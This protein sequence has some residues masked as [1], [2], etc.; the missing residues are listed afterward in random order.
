MGKVIHNPLTLT[1]VGCLG[2]TSLASPARPQGRLGAAGVG[3]GGFRQLRGPR[4]A[5]RA[6]AGRGSAAVT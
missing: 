4:P 5:L 3:T 1:A 2:S 6:V